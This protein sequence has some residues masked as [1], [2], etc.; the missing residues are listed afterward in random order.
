MC[1]GISVGN[2]GGIPFANMTLT[3]AGSSSA[4]ATY[5]LPNHIFA[6]M[7]NVGMIIANVLTASGTVTGITISVNNQT[8]TL[9]DTTGAAIT[10]LDA[11]ERIIFFNKSNNTLHAVI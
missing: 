6:R 10:S 5:S 7:G 11:G 3:T 4:N 1:N 2:R 8:M 9:T